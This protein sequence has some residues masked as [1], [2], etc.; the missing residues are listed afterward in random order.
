MV[1]SLRLRIEAKTT[2]GLGIS[3]AEARGV[4]GLVR[5]RQLGV[6]S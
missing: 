3:V 1:M 2:H 4:Q 5:F 6:A